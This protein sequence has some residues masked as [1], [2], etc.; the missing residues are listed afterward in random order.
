MLVNEIGEEHLG[1]FN[2]ASSQN[3]GGD[4]R[5]SAHD[6]EESI[7]RTSSLYFSRSYHLQT[8]TCATPNTN[9]LRNPMSER[10]ETI[11]SQ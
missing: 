10:I 1:I 6:Q 5:N 2:F 11:S 3:P 4:F 9:L 7:C 8:V